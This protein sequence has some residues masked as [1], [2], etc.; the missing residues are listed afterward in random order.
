MISTLQIPS[1][2][3]AEPQSDLEEVTSQGSDTQQIE[4][5]TYVSI[6]E[7]PIEDSEVSTISSQYSSKEE[8][9]P[10]ILH[11]NNFLPFSWISPWS[12]RSP[13]LKMIIMGWLMSQFQKGD[14]IWQ[15]PNR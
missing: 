5:L 14:I 11:K 6:Q 8:L 15:Q 3:V 13:K 1:L 9:P 7:V 2:Y 10:N 4:Q 12:Q